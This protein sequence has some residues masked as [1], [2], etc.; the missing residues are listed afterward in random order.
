MATSRNRSRGTSSRRGSRGGETQA[1]ARGRSRYRGE[2]GRRQAQAEQ[3][4]IRER[5]AQRQ[6]QGN[7]PF[8]FWMP[9][10]SERKVLVLDEQPDFFRYEHAM[11]NRDSGRNDLY[12][13]CIDEFDTC[14]VCE[15]SDSRPYYAM[16]LTVIDLEP[17]TNKQ[18]EE[19]EWSRKLFVV[20]S[21]MQRAWTREYE[22]NGSLRGKIF[23]IFRDGDKDPVTGNQIE[24]DLEEE[25]YTEDEMAEFE[26]SWTD[27]ENRT[28]TEDCS[29]CFDYEEIMPEMTSD[30]LLRISG[31]NPA[32]GSRQAEEEELGGG[33]RS[34]RGSRST[35]RGRR[36]RNEE[37]EEE[38][39][40]TESADDEEG[41][42]EPDA[43]DPPFD[44]DENEEETEEEEA[45]R[46]RRGRG[47]R[48]GRAEPEPEQEEEEAPRRGRRVARRGRR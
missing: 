43:S 26:R 19:V 1:P 6:A 29:V 36:G 4:R 48:R 41:W 32:P 3:E 46:G 25:P 9:P 21:G 18:G 30:E 44:P 22:R 13:D 15:N 38:E 37:T 47:S 39:E 28:H 14:P 12:T 45:P 2:E 23:T 10:N 11:M 31:G 42:E 7:Q 20:K 40:T 33:G 34:R 17:Y 27:R 16:Y 35:T 8:R 5:R 24:E